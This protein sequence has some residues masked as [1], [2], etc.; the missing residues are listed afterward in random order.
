VRAGR[1]RRGRAVATAALLAAG[2]AALAPA[3]LA[4]PSAGPTDRPVRVTTVRDPRIAESSGLAVS[5]TKPDVL[6]T[7]NDSGSGPLI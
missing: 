2:G 4:S 1:A 3:A 7:V 5:P 6:W